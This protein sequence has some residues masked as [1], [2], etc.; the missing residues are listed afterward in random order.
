MEREYVDQRGGGS[1]DN[2]YDEDRFWG[3]HYWPLIDPIEPI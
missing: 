2:D 3:L 1:F